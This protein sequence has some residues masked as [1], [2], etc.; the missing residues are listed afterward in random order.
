MAEECVW[1]DISTSD[2]FNL[3]I[4]Y[5]YFGLTNLQTHL[6]IIHTYH[7]VLLRDKVMSLSFDLHNATV[8]DSHMQCH[9]PTMP[10]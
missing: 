10:L 3:L 9:A 4:G 8:F 2:G 5:H 7:A 1:V 6:R